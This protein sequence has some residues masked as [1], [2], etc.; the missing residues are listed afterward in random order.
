MYKRHNVWDED[1]WDIHN[2]GGSGY[3][4]NKPGSSDAQQ[5]HK[6]DLYSSANKDENKIK[7]TYRSL[8]QKD[9]EKDSESKEK[10]IVDTVEEEEKKQHN[11]EKPEDFNLIRKEIKPENFEAGEDKETKKKEH[12]SIEEAID[13][14][15]KEEKD[16]V[17]KD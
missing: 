6:G 13:K 17:F 5:Y 16:T 4:G 3:A 11:E 10:S 9:E 8:D 14:A 12:K 7:D 2:T 15:I 1:K